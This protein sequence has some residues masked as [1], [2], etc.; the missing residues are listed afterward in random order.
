MCTYF[1]AET[2]TTQNLIDNILTLTVRRLF[3][4]KDFNLQK[5]GGTGLISEK[6]NRTFVCKT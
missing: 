3:H 6:K 2:D 4:R 1:K 5:Y